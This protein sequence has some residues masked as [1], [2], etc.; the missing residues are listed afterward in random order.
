MLYTDNFYD[1]LALTANMTSKKNSICDII[2]VK[3]IEKLVAK[4]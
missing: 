4:N 3:E 2:T 1:S